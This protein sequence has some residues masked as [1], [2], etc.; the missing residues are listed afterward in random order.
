M[1]F[2]SHRPALAC[3]CL[4]FL[5]VQKSPSDTRPL[6]ED[7]GALRLY[8]L[9][10]KLHT[11]ARMMHTVA[12][13]DDEDGGMMTLEARGKGVTIE[14]FTV[15]R[16]EGGQNKFGAE[17]SDDLGILR[18]LELLQADKYYG[19]EQR[20]S[21]VVDFGFSKTAEETFNK[22]HGHD[23]ALADM[24]RAIRVFR[25]DVITSRFSGTKRDGHGNHEAAGVLTREAFRAAGDPNR[26][27]EQIKEGLLP[28]QA[29]KFYHD[30]L[31]GSET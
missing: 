4:L 15:T 19:V 7:T 17:S 2:P 21:S 31:P 26:F 16:G 18:T 11:T 24:V 3:I 23:I 9:L 14:L 29:K 25:P 10:T 22:W 13:P 5:L 8:Q 20:F 27:L 6:P 1:R 12:H 28:W 30:N